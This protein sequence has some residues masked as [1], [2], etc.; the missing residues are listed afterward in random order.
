[1]KYFI[2]QNSNLAVVNS[3]FRFFSIILICLTF[4][5]CKQETKM[6]DWEFRQSGTEQWIA[7]DVP[8]TVHTDLLANGL[9]PDP[10]IGVN[11]LAVQ[12]VENEDWEYR[13]SFTLSSSLMKNQ[14]IDLIFEGLDTYADVYLN[15]S[16]IIQADNMHI[17]WSAEVKSLLKTGT[18]DLR[19]YFY[20]PVKRSQQKLEELDYLIPASNE[21]KPIGTQSSI[22]SRKA[23]YHYG[24][25]WAPRLVTSGIWRNVKFRGWNTTKIENV[26]FECKEI[27]GDTAICFLEIDYRSANFEVEAEITFKGS[28]VNVEKLSDSQNKMVYKVTVSDAEIWWPSGMGEQNLYDL[29]IDLLVDGKKTDEY[30]TRVGLRKVE[31]I[32]TPDDKGR[33]FYLKINNYPLFI[34]GAN[35][36]PTDFFNPRAIAKYE[37]VIQDAVDAN[38]NMLRVWGGAVYEDE[39]FYELCDE[40]GILIWQDFMFACSMI[41]T[42]KEHIENIK[43]EAKSVISRLNNH[44][45]VVLWCGNNENLTGWK[46]WGW[47]NSYDL[48]AA[49][50]VKVWNTYDSLFNHTLKDCVKK[51]G[52]DIYWPT[53]PSSDVNKTQNKY[54]GDQH[55]WGVWFGQM[56]FDRFQENA[57]R[58]ISEYGLQSFPEMSSIQKFDPSID[59]W[60]LETEALNFRQRSKMLWIAEGFD[61]F[62]MM[63]YYAELYFPASNNLED[64]I[65]VSQLTQA[66]AL[67]TAVEAH[68]RNKPYTM[69]SMYW[70]INDMWPTI[71]WSTI[72]YFGKWK[73]AHYAI[74]EAYKPVVVSA[75][76]DKEVLKVHVI[77]DLL[78]SVEGKLE[79]LLKNFSG[80]ILKSWKVNCELEKLGNEIVFEHSMSEMLDQYSAK[81]V[82]LEMRLTEGNQIIDEGLKYFV[83]PKELKLKKAIITTSVNAY[84]ITLKFDQL[85]LGVYLSVGNIEGRFSDNYFDLL[86]GQNKT[87]KFIINEKDINLESFLKITSLVDIIK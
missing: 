36:I 46:E 22:F 65:Y 32:Q 41:P 9:I 7:A 33:S 59:K 26:K 56:P 78:K 10:F 28:P 11:E 82:F 81:E 57:G 31:F 15:D 43:Q 44:P 86:P 30:Q 77:S 3:V 18:N 48:H 24:W 8:G 87:V 67:K 50:S 23:Q 14:N 16:L 25:D 62:D 52:N 45:S 21:I 37:N 73:A 79:L 35:Y 85:A 84:E 70:Q 40:N 39:K 80:D 61:G 55:E 83:S 60:D 69:G 19:I 13:T 58:F 76:I 54:S 12:W 6:A 75:V 29:N 64:F 49:D 53:S 71:S 20:S 2:S 4:Y 17:P 68:R 72:D 63:K 27:I 5:S 47:Q 42:Q 38:M 51:Y 1:M 66:L 34:K 74:K